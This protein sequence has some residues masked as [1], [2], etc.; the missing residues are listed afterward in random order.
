MIPPPSY[1]KPA[2]A[3]AIVAIPLVWAS[4]VIQAA[5]TVGRWPIVVQ[6]VF[7]IIAGIVWIAPMKP[8]LRWS[9]TGKWRE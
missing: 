5:D 1:R 9:E 2:A 6:T 8:L 7:Y 3:L 4:I